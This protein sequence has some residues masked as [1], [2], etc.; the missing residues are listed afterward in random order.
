MKIA[1][2][3]NRAQK[4]EVALAEV[5]DSTKRKNAENSELSSEVFA[6]YRGAGVPNLCVLARTATPHLARANFRGMP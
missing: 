6:P 2:G 1:R 4:T 3:P 5:I